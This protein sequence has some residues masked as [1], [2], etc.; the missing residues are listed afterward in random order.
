MAILPL[1]HARGGKEVRLERVAGRESAENLPNVRQR[2]GLRL[3]GIARHEPARL[4]VQLILAEHTCAMR[5]VIGPIGLG[6]VVAAGRMK[7]CG[8][9]QQMPAYGVR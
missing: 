7:S 6:R 2:N 1:A 8:V 5:A 9:L 3:E 4:A